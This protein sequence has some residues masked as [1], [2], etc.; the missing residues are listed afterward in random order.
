MK[1][2]NSFNPNK[3]DLKE[4]CF[5]EQIK[6]T[7]KYNSNL[8]IK[9][10]SEQYICH[11]LQFMRLSYGLNQKELAIILEISQGTV[12]KIENRKMLPETSVLL[13]I[14]N[15]LQFPFEWFIL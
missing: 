1:Q 5:Y 11:V 15:R 14:S 8:N 7:F 3:L 10:K 13:R 4:N 2:K 6:K 9:L 12:S